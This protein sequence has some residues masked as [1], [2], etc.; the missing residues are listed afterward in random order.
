[1]NN[2]LSYPQEFKIENQV[3]IQY[4]GDSNSVTIPNGVECIANLAFFR[5]DHIKHLFIPDSVREIGNLAFYQ[6]SGLSELKLPQSLEIIGENACAMLN[7]KE[8]SVPSGVRIIPKGAF[9][10]NHFLK[11]LTLHEGISE[12]SNSAFRTCDRLTELNIPPSVKKIDAY[13]F[14]GCSSLISVTLCDEL[15]EIGVES[16]GNCNNLRKIK[17]PRSVKYIGHGAF[18]DSSKLTVFCDDPKNIPSTWHLG[19]NI[20]LKKIES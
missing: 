4:I 3:L 6:M 10:Y 8:I 2:K 14:A 16:F 15:E 7:V 20:K 18:P 9:S 11:R 13:A 17:I 1:M 12:I 5:K 19:K